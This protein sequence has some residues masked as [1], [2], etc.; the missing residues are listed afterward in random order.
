[1]V[2]TKRTKKESRVEAERRVVSAISQQIAAE[3]LGFRSPS[4]LRNMHKAPRLPDGRYDLRDLVPWIV[5]QNRTAAGDELLTAPADSPA[6]ER[7]RLARAQGAELDLAERVGTLM[8]VDRFRRVT[9]MLAA[10][11]RGL[12]ER[13]AKQYGGDVA[14]QFSETID[15]VFELIDQFLD[16]GGKGD[17]HDPQ[18]TDN[19]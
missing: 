9:N 17:Q 6:L 1:M 7:Y 16:D 8:S 10:A 18:R 11:Y 4:S 5:D 2:R 12:G 14:T 19:T 13:L 15:E 3:V